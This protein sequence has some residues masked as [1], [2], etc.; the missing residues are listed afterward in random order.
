MLIEQIRDLLTLATPIAVIG[1]VMVALLQLRN[2]NRLRQIDTVMRIYLT[3]GTEWF[4]RHYRRVTNWEFNTFEKFQEKATEDDYMSLFVVSVF[5][6]NMG[7]LF[8][9]KLAPLDLLDDLLS[10]PVISAWSSAGPIWVGLRAKYGQPQWAE[11]FELLN[12]VM[13]AQLQK[14]QKSKKT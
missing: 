9:R 11:W 2:Q 12:N 14:L 3:F 5:F 6:E 1:G 8:K 4:V 10:G 7:L 13:R